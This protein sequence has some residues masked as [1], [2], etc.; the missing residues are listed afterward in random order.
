[1][2]K[3]L[4]DIGVL[5]T[6]AEHQQ[7][8]IVSLIE[9]EG[10]TPYS[11]PLI[12]IDSP[13]SWKDADSAIS[14]IDSYDWILFTSV[15]AV[16]GFIGRA[17]HAGT[18]INQMSAKKIAAV[19]SMTR[20]RLEDI[21]LKVSLQPIKYDGDNLLKSFGKENIYE[22]RILFPGAEYGREH[23]I[24]GLINIG[25]IVISVPVYRTIPNDDVDSNKLIS[26]LEDGVIQIATFFSPSTF[27]VFLNHLPLEVTESTINK[28][29]AIAVIGSTTSKYINGLGFNIEIVPEEHT[30]FGLIEAMKSWVK[31]SGVVENNQKRLKLSDTLNE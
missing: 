8:D 5:V 27:K 16:D 30:V 25:A 19:G 7:S 10:G 23:L 29:V 3:P 17:K 21:G 20:K 31:S 9:N 12:K 1:M 6:R 2:N 18:D 13:E 26:F 24:D 11:I 14:E 28:S 15:N 22:K 4:K